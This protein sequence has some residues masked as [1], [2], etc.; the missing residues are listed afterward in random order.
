VLA[1][2]TGH[3]RHQSYAAF[4]AGAA[5]RW[6][7]PVWTS[8][9]VRRITGRGQLTG[10]EL[11]PG[12]MPEPGPRGSRGSS[13]TPPRRSCGSRPNAISAATPPPLGRFVLRSAVFRSLARLEVR[14]DCQLPARSC[15][16]R[17]IPGRPAHLGASWRS[18]VNP[19]G[20]PVQV[21]VR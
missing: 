7:T 14:Q 10:A 4:R 17:L 1:L 11:E 8:A 2:V 21:S 18:Q 13:C 6:R 16:Q 15:P 3:R 12:P 20:G 5:L 9:A 19:A